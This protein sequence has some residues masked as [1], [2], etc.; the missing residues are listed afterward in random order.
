MTEGKSKEVTAKSII[1]ATGAR[2]REL[3]HIKQDGKQVIGYREA[4]TF[5]TTKEYGCY[6][7]RRHWIRVCLFL[8]DSGHRSHA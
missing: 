5:Q 3:P 7:L 8:S 6:G 2:S 1:V 4:M